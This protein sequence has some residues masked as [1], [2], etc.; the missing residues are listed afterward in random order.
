[1]GK[2]VLPF[3]KQMG[4]KIEQ[5]HFVEEVAKRLSIPQE[6]IW[7]ELEK[8][9]LPSASGDLKE[10]VEPI[11]KEIPRSR[12]DIIEQ[13]IM[14]ILFGRRVLKTGHIN[15][16]SGETFGGRCRSATH[17]EV[18]ASVCRRETRARI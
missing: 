12:K 8:M 18:K 7:A 3:I 2:L 13:Q 5:A 15:R 17:G 10:E 16:K 11:L 4:N 14:S 9:L 6:P 1:M